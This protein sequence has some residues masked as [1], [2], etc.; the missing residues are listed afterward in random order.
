MNIKQ[1][2]IDSAPNSMN[3][4]FGL[5]EDNNMYYWDPSKRD[6]VFFIR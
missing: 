5:G 2:A 4:I 6:W 1:I 3:F